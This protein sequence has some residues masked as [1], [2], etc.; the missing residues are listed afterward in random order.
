MKPQSVS[1]RSWNSEVSPSW[2][3]SVERYHNVTRSSNHPSHTDVVGVF[4]GTG[5]RFLDEQL[6]S[7]PGKRRQK[8]AGFETGK[9]RTYPYHGIS[10]GLACMHPSSTNTVFE[11]LSFLS[12]HTVHTHLSPNNAPTTHY[13]C[14]TPTCLKL[15]AHRSLDDGTGFSF[16]NNHQTIYSFYLG[17][18]HC[19]W[20]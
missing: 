5:R 19:A 13:P 6:M 16:L 20:I 18:F 1:M 12:A 9:N 3:F 17:T 8:Q 11:S 15:P 10:L 7:H 2:L 4:Y 14:K